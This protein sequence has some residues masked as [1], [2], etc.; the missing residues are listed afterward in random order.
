MNKKTIILAGAEINDY[1]WL[2]E[3][4]SHAETIICAD[5]GLHH[6]QKIGIIPHKIIGDF[7]SVNA[8]LL[9]AFEGKA[10]IILNPDQYATDLMKAL[11]IAP[12]N[13][14]IDIYGAVGQRAD[15]DFSN[16]LIMMTHPRGCDS[17]LHTQH[18]LRCVIKRETTFPCSIGDMFGVFPLEPT[19]GLHYQGLQW[20]DDGLDEPHAFGWNGSCN[21]AIA[22]EVTIS[23]SS[24]A[25]LV[26]QSY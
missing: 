7:D 26:T 14:R 9:K 4:T 22:D 8:D 15:H 2:Y 20:P 13:A 24:G 16:I 19:S 11:D 1:E 12:D 3:Q 6:A 10:E 23:L 5:S 18:D 17:I 25:V 21:P